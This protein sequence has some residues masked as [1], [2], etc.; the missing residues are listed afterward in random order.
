MTTLNRISIFL[1]ATVVLI[2]LGS[3]GAQSSAVKRRLV[4]SVCGLSDEL[5]LYE[6]RTVE[7]RGLLIANHHGF[8]LTDDKCPGEIL[9][10]IPAKGAISEQLAEM[11]HDAY[12]A[13]VTG[14]SIE[15]RGVFDGAVYL[16][17]SGHV[18]FSARDVRDVVR[19]EIRR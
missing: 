16:D 5:K 6:G 12:G 10:L 18:S 15:L 9:T 4:L 2:L 17:E 19:G 13:L 1:L 11:Y 3:C 14:V 8:I 7:V